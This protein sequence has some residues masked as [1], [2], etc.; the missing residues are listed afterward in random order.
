MIRLALPPLVIE[1]KPGH[2]GLDE[3]AV[4]TLE[5]PENVERVTTI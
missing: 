5:A 3:R 1:A 4:E 2:F